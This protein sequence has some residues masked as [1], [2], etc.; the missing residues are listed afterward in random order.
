MAREIAA[1]GIW[2]RL[3][4]DP[5]SGA[6]LD[7]GRRTYQPPA[8]LRDL[9][10][11]RDLYCRF[12]TCRQSA[13]TADLDH[14]VPYHKGGTTD[15]T[16]LYAACRHHHRLKTRA[17]GWR[18]AQDLDGTITW[19]TPTGQTGSSGPHDYRTTTAEDR[20]AQAGPDPPPF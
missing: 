18:V 20:S 9:V 7:H 6:V 17:G 1:D 12:P 19:T 16:N 11:A 13:A 2:R 14:A 8:A 4:V 3:I 15:P 5:M 10:R